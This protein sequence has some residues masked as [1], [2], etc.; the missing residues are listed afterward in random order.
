LTVCGGSQRIYDAPA[1]H[2]DEAAMSPWTI[3]LIGAFT[4]A[5]LAVFIYVSFHEVRRS[6]A[7]VTPL[8]GLLPISDEGATDLETPPA[9]SLRVLVATDGS[10]CSDRAVQSIAMRP[11]PP[12]SEIEVVSVAHTRLPDVP[13]PLLMLEAAHIDAA[14][15]DLLRAPARVRRAQKCLASRS[16]VAVTGTVLE[17]NPADVILGEAERWRADLVVVGSHGYGPLTRRV[18]GSVSQAVAQHA[19]CSVE[20]V[21]CPDDGA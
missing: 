8:R 19:H 11:W 14:E 18:L 6:P 4:A 12:G 21:R 5:L 7:G 9:R 17:G 3:F 15:A 20:I 13:D 16:G 10:T 2:H 1:I